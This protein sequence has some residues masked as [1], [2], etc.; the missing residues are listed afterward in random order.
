MLGS[1][2]MSGRK[3]EAVEALKEMVAKENVRKKHTR[4]N[5]RTLEVHLILGSTM[6]EFDHRSITPAYVG[7]LPLS[8]DLHEIKT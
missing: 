4:I 6:S 1:L 7:L 3:P 8:S 5:K 2:T